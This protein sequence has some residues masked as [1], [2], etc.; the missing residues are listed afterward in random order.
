LQSEQARPYFVSVYADGKTQTFPLPVAKYDAFPT[1]FLLD[2]SGRVWMG[3]DKGEFGGECSY[4][5]LHTGNVLVVS[6]DVSGVL[7][8][9]HSADG[10]LLVYGG[11]SH[12]WSHH[13]YIADIKKESLEYVRRF[14]SDSWQ[15]P[16]PDKAQRPLNPAKSGQGHEAVP[17]GNMP[18][19]PVDLVIEDFEGRGFWVVSAHILYH[20]DSQFAQWAKTADLGGRWFGGRRY[21]VG[22]TPTVNRLIIVP[23]RREALLVVMGRD[24]LERVS[25][26]KVERLPFAGQLESSVID[27]WGTSL[28]TVFLTNDFAHVAWRLVGD[29]WQGLCFFPNRPPSDQSADWEFAE[30]FGDDDKGSL[31]FTGSGMSPGERDVVRLNSQE[32]VE[33]LDTWNDNSSQWDTSFLITSKGRLLS[34]SGGKLRIRQ[35]TGWR[36][37]G[38]YTLP[39]PLERMQMLVGRRY[40]SFG[41]AGQTQFFSDADFG[42]FL[43]LTRNSDD[44]FHLVPTA[45]GTHAAPA[46]VLD[47]FVDRDGWSL[48]A[49]PRG[50]FR[51]RP[52]DGQR[53]SIPTP[54]PAEEFKSICRDRQR[55]L[56]AAGDR[57]YISSN[58]GK[59]WERV[60]LPMVSKTDAKRVR[61]NPRSRR[62][63]ILSLHDQGVVFVDW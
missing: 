13:G 50:L 17:P 14:E 25:R 34:M 4:M 9:L 30:P 36:I 11:M 19:G 58:E 22:N 21:S 38:Q 52:Q 20:A 16:A 7:G 63:L 3:A 43:Q 61:P 39:D 37:A 10:R 24:G 51:F 48:I 55:R 54:N 47:A 33:V 32:T 35:G 8:F 15:R 18:R 26:G 45:Y 2:D 62:G 56:W 59:S 5:D 6:K 31:A 42:E 1:A 44:T 23:S 40:L 28:G 53:E 41:K 57:L 46:E 29:H 12:F 27:S 60:N 49:T